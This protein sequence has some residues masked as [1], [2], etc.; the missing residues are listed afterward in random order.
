MR[1]LPPVVCWLDP[2]LVTGIATYG[3]DVFAAYQ[4]E[5]LYP[6]GTWLDYTLAHADEPMAIGWES[7]LVTGARS[8]ES[9]VSLRVIGVAQYLALKHG[10]EILPEMPSSAR[11]GISPAILKRLDAYQS[12]IPHAMDAMRHLVAWMAREH[13]LTE[14]Q[15]QAFTPLTDRGTP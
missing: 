3:H 11:V 9:A 15:R 8:R 1:G 10:A 13:L 5:G 7:Y 14:N 2:G 12:G 4:I 6:F